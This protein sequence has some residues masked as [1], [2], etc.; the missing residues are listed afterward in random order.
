[1]QGLIASLG[2]IARYEYVALDLA[3]VGILHNRTSAGELVEVSVLQILQY[4]EVTG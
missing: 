1:M 2:R 4:Q 3:V